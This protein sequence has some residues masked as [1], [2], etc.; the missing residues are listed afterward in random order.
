MIGL[1]GKKIGMTQVFGDKGEAI[2]VTVIEAG[3][4]TVAEVRTAEKCGYSAVQLGFGSQKPRRFTRPVL[5]GEPL[6]VSVQLVDETRARF[7]IEADGVTA[8][9]GTL[10]WAPVT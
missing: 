8:V 10:R 1:I 2:P 6:H 5:P 4:C 9:T 3:P 7:G